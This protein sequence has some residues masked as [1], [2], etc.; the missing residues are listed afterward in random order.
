MNVSPEQRQAVF[1]LCAEYGVAKLAIFGS[2][3]R[4]DACAD[5]DLD[6]LVEFAPGRSPGLFGLAG[7]AES[8][9]LVLSGVRVDLRTPRD[10]S[11]HFR[12]EVTHSAEVLYAA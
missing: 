6:L 8:L 12:D 2:R 11:R 9:S 3:M 7:L 10:L 1:R 5:S 4:G